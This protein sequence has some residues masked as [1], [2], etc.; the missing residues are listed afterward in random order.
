MTVFVDGTGVTAGTEGCKCGRACE[1]PC[2]QRVGITT[3][4]CCEACPPLPAVDED[5][6]ADTPTKYAPGPDNARADGEAHWRERIAA[7]VEAM[8]NSF[9]TEHHCREIAARIRSAGA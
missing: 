9:R 6:D 4:P 2:W 3:S 5:D 8:D 1:M 7:E